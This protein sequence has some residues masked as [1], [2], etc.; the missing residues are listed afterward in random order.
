MALCCRIAW[1][2]AKPDAVGFL[3]LYIMIVNVKLT[4]ANWREI[5][6]NSS[7][8]GSK[9]A[10][11]GSFS[12]G[13]LHNVSLLATR[14][15]KTFPLTFASKQLRQTSLFFTSVANEVFFCFFFALC[16]PFLFSD[17]SVSTF[18]L[19]IFLSLW[20][21][22]TI[23]CSVICPDQACQRTVGVKRQMAQAGQWGSVHQLQPQR[24]GGAWKLMRLVLREVGTHCRCLWLKQ[25]KKGKSHM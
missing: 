18:S 19:L 8:N 3:C 12:T 16:L 2:G 22:N 17:E 21:R 10:V 15:W 20:L 24:A 13:V 1:I 14:W 7:L 25:K 9:S 11:V 6:L 5:C 23:F 4:A